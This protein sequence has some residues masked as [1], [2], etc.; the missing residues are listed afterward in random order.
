MR[1]AGKRSLRRSVRREIKRQTETRDA[2]ID[3]VDTAN[4]MLWLKIH[5]SAH[6]IPAKYPLDWSTLPW[7][8]KAGVSVHIRHRGGV[9]G[10]VDVLGPGIF[11]PGDVVLPETPPGED[12]VITGCSIRAVA[13]VEVMAV[14][15]EVGY[16]R[17]DNVVYEL[18]PIPLGFDLP[19]GWEIPLALCAGIVYLDAAP[20]AGYYRFDLICVGTDGVI[21]YIAGTPATD[22][23]TVPD[24]PADHV[25]LGTIMVYSGMTFVRKTDITDVFEPGAP[26]HIKAT[27]EDPQ[28]AYE[29]DDTDITV[30]VYDQRDV[31]LGGPSPNGWYITLEFVQGTGTIYSPEEGISETK[32]GGSTGEGNASYTFTYFRDK[33]D[34]LLPVESMEY[35][36]NFSG[37]AIGPLTDDANWTSRWQSVDSPYSWGRYDVES[38]AQGY[39][40]RAVKFTK[41]GTDGRTLVTWDT[42]GNVR[43]VMILAKVRPAELGGNKCYIHARASGDAILTQSYMVQFTASSFWMGSFYQGG[44][45]SIDSVAF[46]AQVDTDYWMRFRLV[47][48]ELKAKYWADGGAEPDTWTLEGDDFRYPNA[49]WVGIGGYS[50]TWW[51]DAL[52]VETRIAEITGAEESPIFEAVLN[53]S[54]IRSTEAYIELLDSEGNPIP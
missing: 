27:V 45:D 26:T 42:I 32:I 52:G 51:C 30:T 46:T 2:V 50:R 9:R 14:W 21:D 36:T 43:D 31:A 18:E 29:L 40:D 38:A 6:L 53:W 54:Y 20:A 3:Q 22:S 11:I 10:R 35:Y 39:G 44:Y 8:V 12:A 24:T 48:N 1:F 5:G 23:P 7:W 33:A 49:G 34:L 16:Y 37:V 13:G 15:I 17:I 41:G 25:A 4:K 28:M 47:G 19:A